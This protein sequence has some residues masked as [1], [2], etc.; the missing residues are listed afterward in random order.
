VSRR[1]PSRRGATPEVRVRRRPPCR[2]HG[3]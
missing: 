2:A 3:V 1:S